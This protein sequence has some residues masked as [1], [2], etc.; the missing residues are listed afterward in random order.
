MNTQSRLGK[1]PSWQRRF[2]LLG[3][4]ACSLTGISYLIGHEFYIQRKF[5]GDHSVLTWH[6]IT[7]M[8][9]TLA[10]GSILP[11]HL[12]AGLQSRRK[13]ASGFSQLG[14]LSALMITG[15]LLYYGPEE[16]RDVVV[17]MHWIIGLVFFI[18]FLL[19]G[20]LFIK[21]KALDTKKV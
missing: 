17:M 10:I 3:I 2:V 18:F 12:K 13:I 19:H 4:L 9:A 15:A 21:F 14:C 1:M 5:L 20:V 8:L 7:A 6:G 11:F 16:M